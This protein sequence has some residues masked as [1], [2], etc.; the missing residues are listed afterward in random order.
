MNI[1]LTPEQTQR[2]QQYLETRKYPSVTAVID[3][4]LKLLEATEKKSKRGN[5]LLKVFEQTGFLGSLPNASPHL[6][7]N[8]KAITRAE[9]GSQHDS[10]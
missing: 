7:S 9:M 5:K 4:A 8:Y 3:E 10:R 2:I 6:S 1:V